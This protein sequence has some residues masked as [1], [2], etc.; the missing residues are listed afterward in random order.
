M[1]PRESAGIVL[2]REARPMKQSSTGYRHGL[3]VV[4][5]GR[6]KPSPTQPPR[7]LAGM[8]HLEYLSD[9]IR[10][11]QRIAGHVNCATLA[12]ILELGLREV[13]V[14]RRER[15]GAALNPPRHQS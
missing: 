1:V 11:L 15:R 9:M 10:Q 6:D 14:K 4:Q 3:L 8:E 7:H 12:G 2:K 5:G 13:D